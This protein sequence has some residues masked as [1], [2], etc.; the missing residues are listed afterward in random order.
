MMASFDTPAANGDNGK[1]AG[2]AKAWHTERRRG[3]QLVMF[4]CACTGTLPAGV[5]IEK[6]KSML[7]D[8]PQEMPSSP[9]INTSEDA[10]TQVGYAAFQYC[11]VTV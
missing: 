4:R 10:M 9:M 3:T 7:E 2:E 8:L 5:M 1:R 11:M 6:R